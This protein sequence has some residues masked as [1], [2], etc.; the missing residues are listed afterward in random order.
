MNLQKYFHATYISNSRLMKSKREWSPYM[1]RIQVSASGYLP[2]PRWSSLIPRNSKK[3][4]TLQARTR[5]RRLCFTIPTYGEAWEPTPSIV[6]HMG[7]LFFLLH[8]HTHK[9]RYSPYCWKSK[10]V[11]KSWQQLN[12]FSPTIRVMQRLRDVW[13]Q[14]V[15]TK[16]KLR[17]KIYTCIYIFFLWGVEGEQRAANA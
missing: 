3:E 4:W 8:M 11:I 16:I 10:L 6:T 1:K 14:N 17:K 15:R 12:M 13:S 9:K 2:T 7:I 5:G